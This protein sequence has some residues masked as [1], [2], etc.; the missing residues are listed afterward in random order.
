MNQ[1]NTAASVRAK[2][3]QKAR[4]EKRD[5]TFV[6]TRYALER[7]LYRLGISRH[8]ESSLLK[9][10]L[11]FDLWFDTPHRP[12][13]DID[14]LGFGPGEDTFLTAAFT[15]LCSLSIEDGVVFDPASVRATEI[16]KTSNYAGTRLTLVGWLDGARCPVQVDIAFGDAI[17]APPETMEYPVLF[18][19]FPPPRLKVYPKLT[20]IAE[21]L[22]TMVALGIANSRMKDFFDLWVLSEHGEYDGLELTRAID[23]TFGRR[24]TPVPPG[25]PFALTDDFAADQQK[26]A[27]W[28]AFLGKNRLAAVSLN[29]LVLDLRRFLMPP[30]TALAQGQAFPGNWSRASGWHE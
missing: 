1:K 6:L 17:T 7:L 12:T 14:L 3:L 19:E 27:Q 16:R 22:E 15:E 24:R 21:K 8:A 4:D 13:R 5:F 10:A 29:D 2:L 30:L 23:A 28:Q 18:S 20:V 9:G 11:L 25:V 26:Q